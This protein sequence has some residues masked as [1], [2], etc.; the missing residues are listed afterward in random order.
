MSRFFCGIWSRSTFAPDAILALLYPWDKLSIAIS[1]PA[2][3][4]KISSVSLRQSIQIGT[5]KN[6]KT[7]TFLSTGT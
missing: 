6:K 7:C 1:S 2:K 4:K 5:D 3:R